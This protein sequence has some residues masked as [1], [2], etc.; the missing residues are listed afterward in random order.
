MLCPTPKSYINML[1]P[2]PKRLHMLCPTPKRVLLKKEEA[3]E[4]GGRRGGGESSFLPQLDKSLL[5]R[6]LEHVV[7]L[8]AGG[9][10]LLLGGPVVALALPLPPGHDE[11]DE[12]ADEGDE[13]HAAHNGAD[14]EGQLLRG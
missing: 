12:E 3:T 9:G 1:C 8:E 10:E 6:N 5:R 11:E 13:G 4:G 2:T 7:Q 14:N